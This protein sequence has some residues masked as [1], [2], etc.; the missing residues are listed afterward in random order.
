[1]ESVRL[2]A[3]HYVVAQKGGAL[4]ATHT[5]HVNVL[6]NVNGDCPVEALG[7]CCG[8]E[9]SAYSSSFSSSCTCTGI[10]IF[11]VDEKQHRAWL[12]R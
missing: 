11:L 1:M 6:V 3:M 12:Y 2:R 9:S 7:I 8:S 5:N 4:V 10:L